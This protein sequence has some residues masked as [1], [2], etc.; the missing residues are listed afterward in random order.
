VGVVACSFPAKLYLELAELKN[1]LNKSRP[2]QA[3]EIKE[4]RHP[5]QTFGRLYERFVRIR[6]KPREI[7]LG[8][9]LGVFIGLTPT[10]GIQM[11]IA[12]FLAAIFKWSK[13]SAACGVW[14]TNPFTAPFIYAATYFVGAKLLGIETAMSLP[15][16]L[17][18]DLVR[19]M[20]S[21]APLIFGALTV[22]GILLGL[23]LA[24]LGYYLAFAA[25]NQYQRRVKAK[26]AAQK[27]RL[28]VKK[29]RL[30]DKIRHRSRQQ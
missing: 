11:P 19:D 1:L 21:N 23:P 3:K 18:W 16:E 4:K 6:G 15:E 5:G 8:F 28:R 26:V 7:A 17:N 24:I 9:A 2:N 13:I 12:V 30:K 14:I 25:V 29:E 22:G 27:A 10:M 20:L